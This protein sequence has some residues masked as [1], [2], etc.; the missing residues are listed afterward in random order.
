MYGSCDPFGPQVKDADMA[1]TRNRKIGIA[2]AGGALVAGV[3]A[4]S[5][6]SL[7]TLTVS[8]LGTTAEV[9]AACQNGGLT[10]T[11]WTPQTYQAAATATPTTGSTYLTGGATLGG[12]SAACQ[13]KPYKL[14]VA[15]ADGTSLAESTGS[16]PAAP[17]GPITFTAVDS[18][19]IEQVTLTI[20]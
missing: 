17:S 20:Y 3:F 15:K 18:K 7:G 14:T 19:L 8:N 11:T 12:L 10:I 2:V 9:V 4:A 16:T 5:A 13:S 1:V 6:A